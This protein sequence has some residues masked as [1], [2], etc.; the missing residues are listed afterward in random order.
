[1]AGQGAAPG[2]LPAPYFTE[3]VPFG[4]SNF[5]PCC[6]AG[7]THRSSPH[8][9]HQPSVSEM[10]WESPPALLALAKSPMFS[11]PISLRGR[12][13]SLFLRAGLG[14]FPNS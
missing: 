8:G 7:G 13:L 14:V 4:N 9:E 6:G 12:L 5:L 3:F 2:L 1:M 11:V 10:R